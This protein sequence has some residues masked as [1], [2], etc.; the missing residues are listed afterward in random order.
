MCLFQESRKGTP[1]GG[2]VKRSKGANGGDG[3]FKAQSSMGPICGKEGDKEEVKVAWTN[4]HGR[5]KKKQSVMT[6]M[7]V[8]SYDTWDILLYYNKKN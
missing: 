4:D 8:T 1:E 6:H 5:S 2:E 7:H 3:I